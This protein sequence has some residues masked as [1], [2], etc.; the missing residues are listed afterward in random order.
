MG[1]RWKITNHHW[2]LT[3]V[4]IKK[5][6]GKYRRI[7][8]KVGQVDRVDCRESSWVVRRAKSRVDRSSWSIF[9]SDRSP[10]VDSIDFG[11]YLL[12]VKVKALVSSSWESISELKRVACHMGSH[13]VT[14]HPTQANTPQC[15]MLLSSGSTAVLSKQKF[16]S[17]AKL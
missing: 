14:C 9:A 13:N 4:F 3:I 11:V 8:Y 5:P 12:K 17:V 7:K 1:C 10:K 2:H 15:C 6:I 16:S